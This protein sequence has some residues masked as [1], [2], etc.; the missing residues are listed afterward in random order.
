MK[1]ARSIFFCKKRILFPALQI[2][3]ICAALMLWFINRGNPFQKEFTPEELTAD[4]GIVTAEGIATDSSLSAGGSIL[5][6]HP[7]SLDRGTYEIH[8]NYN[9]SAEGSNITANTSQLSPLDFHAPDVVLLPRCHTAVMTVELCRSVSDFTIETVFSGNGSISISEI[10]IFETSH[11]Y[12]KNLFYAILLCMLVNLVWLFLQSDTAARKTILA[13][14]GIFLAVCYPLYTDYLIVGHDLPFHLLRIE[15]IAEALK[16]GNPLP[17]KIH[18]F[19]AKDYGYAVGTLYGDALLYFPAILRVLGFSVQSAYKYFVAAVN[20]GTVLISY[21][22]FKTMFQSRKTGLLGCLIYSFSLY[23]LVD[24]YTRASVGE[25]C[26]MMFLPLVLC[27]FFL[28]FS[29]RDGMSPRKPVLLTALGL[30]GLIQTHVLSCGMAAIIIIPVCIVLIRRVICSYTFRVL[31]EALLLT[32]LLNIGFLVP[33]FDYYGTDLNIFSDQWQGSHGFLQASGLFPVQ[34]FSLFQKSNGG[35]G[36]TSTGIMWEMT[37]GT[38][39]LFLC[40]ILLFCYLLLFHLQDLKK[41]QNFYPALLCL[42]TGCLLLYMSTYLFP[43]DS[44]ASL[45]NTVGKLLDNLQFPWRFLAFATVL[46]TFS[47]CFA[48]RAAEQVVGAHTARFVA[49]GMLFLFAV[50]CGW[51]FY[52]FCFDSEPY[53][54]YASTELNTMQMYSYDYLPVAVKP[55]LIQENNIISTGIDI[56]EAYQKRGTEI[57]CHVATDQPGGIDFPLIY[58]TYYTCTNL[59]TGEKLPVSAGYNGML[60]VDFSAGFDGNIRIAFE[61]PWFWRASELVSILTLPV[62]FCVPILYKYTRQPKGRRKETT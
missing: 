35:A 41:L 42:V 58:Y 50:N 17:V 3:I 37:P 14:S 39:I 29:K 10:G 51:Y 9:V 27:G 6:T 45:G 12:K 40:G 1:T 55:E 44:I 16:N 26:A 15:G 11:L 20:L 18:P 61:E 57:T 23:R 53:R 32:I 33:F 60:H 13:L 43:W 8:V 48:V 54:V 22:S 47:T 7:I 25:Y 56:L 4:P 59:D 2:V 62:W 5:Q 34:L 19:W 38:G 46:L 24:T 30:T 36:S 28:A 52:D 49:T 21:F 31:A